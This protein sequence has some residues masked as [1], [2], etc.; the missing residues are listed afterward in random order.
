MNLS[1]KTKLV[2]HVLSEKFS[3]SVHMTIAKPDCRKSPRDS[4]YFS[5]SIQL[6]FCLMCPL[7]DDLLHVK[8]DFGSLA[9]FI[10]RA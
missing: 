7:Q 10:C 2:Y 9:H 8:A 5:W 1:P 6:L 3:I 4:P